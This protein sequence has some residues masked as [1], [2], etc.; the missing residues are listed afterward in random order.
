[1]NTEHSKT[2]IYKYRL[3]DFARPHG[4]EAMPKIAFLTTKEAKE[5]NYAFA[6]NHAQKKYIKEQ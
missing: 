3:F 6:L 5:K 1:M 4:H 2:P